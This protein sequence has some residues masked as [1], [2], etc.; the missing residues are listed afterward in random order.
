MSIL[1]NGDCLEEM[2]QVEDNSIDLILTD[3]PYN[4]NHNNLKWD[5]VDNYIDF[6]INVFKESFRVLKDNGTLYF[7]HNDFKQMTELQHSIEKYTDFKFYTLITITKD[8]YIPKIFPKTKN[9][10]SCCEYLLVYVKDVMEEEKLIQYFQKIYKKI[11]KTKTQIKRDIPLADHCFRVSKNNF[12]LPIKETYDKIID[13][14]KLKDCKLYDKLKITYNGVSQPNHI[15][16]SFKKNKKTKHPCEKPYDLLCNIINTSSNEGDTVLDM[17]MGC[18]STG[19][20]CNSL[21]RNFIG[22]EKN[23]EYFD[24]AFNIINID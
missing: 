9:W 10:I 8:T 21:N 18:G 23:K 4:I 20:A 16:C 2:K 1:Y 24:E 5:T 15:H 11:N 19:I 7:F 14:Y 6:M 12:S 22:I 17:F 13:L 3:P